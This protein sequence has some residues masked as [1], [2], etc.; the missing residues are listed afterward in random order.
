M[1]RMSCLTVPKCQ[2][3]GIALD[4]RGAIMLRL[5]SP[6]DQDT[7]YSIYMH[8]DVIPYLGYDPMSEA[9]FH[10]VFQEL[11]DCRSF[12]VLE[13]EGII[14]AFCRT[15]R[16]PG[17]ASH[18]AT[19]GTLAVAPRWRGTGIARQLLEQI[20]TLL[21]AQGVLRVELMLEVDNPRAFAFYSKLGFQQEGL[22]RAAY[23]RSSDAHYTD[24]IFMARLLAELPTAAS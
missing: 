18:V 16:Q 1:S 15:T 14:A 13:Q 24:E 20:F 19:L 7:V 17:R 5:A 3:A 9:E 22:M 10:A 8:P 11:L 2:A 23:K 4:E 6:D 12:Y 21:K